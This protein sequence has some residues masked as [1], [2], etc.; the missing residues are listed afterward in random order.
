MTNTQ[1]NAYHYGVK[2]G[3]FNSVRHRIFNLLTIQDL[4]LDQIKLKLN[5]NNK[6]DFSGRLSEL[7]DIGVVTHYIKNNKTYYRL[8]SELEVKIVEHERAKSKLTKWLNNGVRNNLL[9]KLEASNI[10][11]DKIIFINNLIK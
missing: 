8:T 5:A 7:N 6:N 3:R 2:I 11:S 1:L 4:T 10:Y 9:T